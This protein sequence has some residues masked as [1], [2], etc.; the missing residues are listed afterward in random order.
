MK[1]KTIAAGIFCLCPN[2]GRHLLMKRRCDVKFAGY[3]GFPGGGFDDEDKR[4]S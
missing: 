4:E 1:S 3:W 2:T